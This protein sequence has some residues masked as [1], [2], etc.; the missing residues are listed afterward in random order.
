MSDGAIGSI[1]TTHHSFRGSFSAVSTPIFASKKSF[2][3]FFQDLRDLHTYAPLGTQ[4]FGK[5]CPQFP[6]GRKDTCKDRLRYSRERASERVMC[7]GP[8]MCCS[9]G[10]S[11]AAAAATCRGLR[12]S[13]A[14]PMVV[15]PTLKR[16]AEREAKTRSCIPNF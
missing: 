1:A 15:A 8:S 5:N 7:R 11:S 16:A 12:A 14:K 13:P 6:E 3:A 2:S 4:I 9:A 10:T